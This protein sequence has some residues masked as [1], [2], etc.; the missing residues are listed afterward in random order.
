VPEN[1]SAGSLE[2]CSEEDVR[3]QKTRLMA[4]MEMF[5]FVDRKA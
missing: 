1:I 4:V 5:I 2:E 3:F